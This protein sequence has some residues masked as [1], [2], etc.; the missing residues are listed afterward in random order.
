M[1]KQLNVNNMRNYILSI[2]LCLIANLSLAQVNITDTIVVSITKDK[3]Y[4]LVEEENK[5][6]S[7]FLPSNDGG[8]RLDTYEFTFLEEVPT[9]AFTKEYSI[10][11]FDKFMLDYY[12]NNIYNKKFLDL[13]RMYFGNYNFTNLFVRVKSENTEKL[14]K[15]RFNYISVSY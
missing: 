14:Y 3:S 13:G 12:Y 8:A 1:T 4:R 10:N 2:T 15:V 11:D 5:I 9:H 7:V 6:S